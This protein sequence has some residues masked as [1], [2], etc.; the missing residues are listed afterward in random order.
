MPNKFTKGSFHFLCTKNPFFIFRVPKV[1]LF[2]EEPT[3]YLVLIWTNIFFKNTRPYFI[4]NWPNVYMLNDF[5]T[6][7]LK[8]TNFHRFSWNGV[9]FELHVLDSLFFIF[10]KI[11]STY[12]SSH[13][14]RDP[15]RVLQDS[16]PSYHRSCPPSWPHFEIDINNSKKI[17]KCKTFVLHHHLCPRIVI[18]VFN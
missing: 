2:C 13:F 11:I 6:P 3:N 17:K 14:I 9:K 5:Y 12:R 7:L 18:I 15:P 16:T 1:G 8:K 10:Q 4:N